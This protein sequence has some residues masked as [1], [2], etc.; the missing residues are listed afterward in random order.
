MDVLLIVLGV[1]LLYFGGEFLVRNSSRLAQAWGLSPMVI[2][3][4]IVAFGTSAPELAVG[5][6]AAARG[7]LEA[8]PP[9]PT[10]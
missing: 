7:E 8:L 6:I 10:E 5:V 3:L 1:T 9:V 4:T 2:G